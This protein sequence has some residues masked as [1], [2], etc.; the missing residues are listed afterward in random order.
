MIQLFRQAFESI[1]RYFKS[2]FQLGNMS[3]EQTYKLIVFLFIEEILRDDKRSIIITEEDYETLTKVVYNLYGTSCLIPYPDRI[4][5]SAPIIKQLEY[6][7]RSRKGKLCLTQNKV[8]RRL[9]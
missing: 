7:L 3:Y 1:K 4:K 2:L 9:Q 6:K 5:Q 8:I